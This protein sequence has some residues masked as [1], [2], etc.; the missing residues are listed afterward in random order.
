MFGWRESTS[1][2]LK[3]LIFL[4]C[5]S[6]IAVE[7]VSLDQPDSSD[8]KPTA[9]KGMVIDAGSGGSRLHVYNWQPRIFKTIPPAI[10]FPTSD[11]R[12]TARMSPGIADFADN[13][14][15]VKM[16]LAPLIDFAIQTLVGDE[17]NF[18]NYPIYFK[19]TGGM[20]EL[21]TAKREELMTW[22]RF[23]LSDKTFCP[24][25]FHP[26][27]AR[28]ISGE[29]EA[30]FSWTGINFL[31]GNLLPASMGV[32]LANGGAFT[33]GTLDLGG[34]S[35]QISFFIKSQGQ[36]RHGHSLVRLISFMVIVGKY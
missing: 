13:P 21:P 15:D 35:S 5:T 32:G 8:I 31:M 30:V 16:Q 6:L 2:I 11:E 14:E 34:A 12:W 33:Y 3:K 28:V 23:Y 17:E 27:F 20:R 22:I 7:S 10:S 25:F 9:T 24:F 4:A 19:A 36:Y 18:P 29:E 1:G 26:D